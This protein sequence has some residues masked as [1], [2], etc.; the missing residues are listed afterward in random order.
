S[1]CGSELVV[2]AKSE[3]RPQWQSGK[4]RRPRA[5]ANTI[6]FSSPMLKT[7]IL[8]TTT[9]R[10]IEYEVVYLTST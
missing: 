2:L 9:T 7:L 8:K 3:S 4:Q 10:F 1:M 5:I 6:D